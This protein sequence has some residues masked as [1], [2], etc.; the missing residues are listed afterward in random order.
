M[1]QAGLVLSL[2]M[3][4]T[5]ALAH[6][7]Q[8]GDI[9]IGHPWSRA[10]PPG[11]DKGVG[12]LTLTNEG[13]EPITVTGAASPRANSVGIHE[14]RMEE[15][16][17]TMAPVS[18]G[19]TVAPGQT[20]EFKPKSYHLMLMGLDQPLEEGERVPVTLVFD[21]APSRQVELHVEGAGGAH[22]E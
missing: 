18:N 7:Y 10:T 16:M 5:S 21:G 13:Q 6:E 9:T 2:L 14:T 12:Y 1:R 15:G 11:V 3:L 8:S 19:L 4:A 20:V 17:M 22:P